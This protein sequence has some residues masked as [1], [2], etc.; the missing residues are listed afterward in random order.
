MRPG[1]QPFDPNPALGLINSLQADLDRLRSLI[2]PEP[3]EFD[4]MDPRNK[5]P[6]GKL[7]ER[8]VEVCYRLFDEGKTRYAVAKAM[9]ISFG[10]ATHRQHAW[11]KA[12]GLDQ[13]QA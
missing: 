5:M 7:T 1:S 6:D 3:L 4:P 9:D 13:G 10:A 8:G 12:R 11:R 2:R